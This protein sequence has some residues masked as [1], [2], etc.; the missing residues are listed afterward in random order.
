LEQNLRACDQ[1]DIVGRSF[2]V[3]FAGLTYAARFHSRLYQYYPN[4]LATR[5]LF[6]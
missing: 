2:T 6:K 3:R 4:Q 1:L 5:Q